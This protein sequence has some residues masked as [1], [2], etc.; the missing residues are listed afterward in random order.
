MNITQRFRIVATDIGIGRTEELLVG[1][2]L[3]HD[4][5]ETGLQLLDGGNVVGEDTHLTGL[6]GDVDLDT[7]RLVRQRMNDDRKDRSMGTAYALALKMVYNRK[8][9]SVQFEGVCK[10]INGSMDIPGEG[11]SGRA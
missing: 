9:M 3:F 11:G 10:R 4:L 8:L 1:T 6:G 2:A 5:N 7:V